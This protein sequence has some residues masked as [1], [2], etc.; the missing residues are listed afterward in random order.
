VSDPLPI[1]E[2]LFTA[3]EVCDI[4][5]VQ[6]HVLLYWETEFPMLEPQRNRAKQRT[7]RQRDVEMILRIRELLYE[8]QYT[9]AGARKILMKEVAAEP[10]N[11]ELTEV[12]TGPT[13]Q[14]NKD[15]YRLVGTIIDEKYKLLDYAGGGGMG[16]VYR[17]RDL[18]NDRRGL[19]AIKILKPDIV[20]RNP[21]YA[22]LFERE[23]ANIQALNHPHIVKV[24]DSGNY[25]DLSYMVMEWVNGISIE[26]AMNQGLLSLERL[27]NVFGQVC[28]AVACAHENSIIHLD[29]KPAN[30]LL[31][32]SAKPEDFV[33]VIDFGL[34]RVITRESGTTVTKF[35]GTDKY[36]AP[37]QFGGRVSHRSDI[38]SLGA[39]L[40]HLITGVIPF[41]MSYINAKMH[42]NLELP[43]I[44]SVTRQREVPATIDQVISKAL[45]RDPDQRQQSAKQLFEEFNE[46]LSGVGSDEQPG[47]VEKS[48]TQEEASRPGRPRTIFQHKG[49]EDNPATLLRSLKRMYKG[50]EDDDYYDDEGENPKV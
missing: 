2:K 9:I 31:V 26:D 4:T 23:A 15:P 24:F 5:G 34:S 25:E 36:C 37:E 43:P 27:T 21:E 29:I 7:Y 49:F 11:R 10:A 1:P 16:A 20:A 42:P 47:A 35:R 12:A 28:D 22:E 46:A 17:A 19:F 40:Y 14:K 48:I 3:R 44:P 41:G 32:T 38:Y 13:T 8:D 30:I 39:T 6:A 45:N 50:E 33:K 18:G